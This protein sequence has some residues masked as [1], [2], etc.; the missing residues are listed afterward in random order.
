M[1]FDV[2]YSGVNFIKYR[3]QTQKAIEKG[4]G[5]ISQN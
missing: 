1:Q 2:G 4:Q 5:G 3:Y